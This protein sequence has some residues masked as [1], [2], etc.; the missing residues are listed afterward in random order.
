M[1]VREFGEK[2]RVRVNDRKHE[3]KYRITTT[4][5]TVHGRHGE[6]V[7]D[8]SFGNVFAVKFLAVPRNAV[9][10]ASLRS[11]KRAAL[12]AGLKLKRLCGDDESIF[13]FNPENLEQ[14]RLALK[15]VGARKRRTVILT[16]EQ[17]KAIGDRLN[18]VRNV[19]NSELPA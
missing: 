12:A 17:R 14:S 3:R 16:P 9:K 2:Y 18:P 10:T 13:H 6:I 11:R 7:A 15:L 4:E 19:N 1:H 8:P 5:D